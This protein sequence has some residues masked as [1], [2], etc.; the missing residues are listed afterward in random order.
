M[1][2]AGRIVV[3]GAGLAGLRTAEAL[4]RHGWEGT[5]TIIGDEPHLPYTRPPLSKKLLAEGGDHA[6]VELRRREEEHETEWLLGLAVAGVDLERKVVGLDDG[7]ELAYDGLVVATGVRARR[8]PPAVGAGTTVLRSLDDALALEPR[9]VPGARVVVIG[10]GFIG[11]EVA[12]TALGRGCEV[13]VV[14]VDEEPMQVPLGTGVGAE[15]RRRH[16]EAG[17][18]FHL[19]VGVSSIDPAGVDLA[20]GTRL[21]ADVIVEAIGSVPNTEWLAGNGLDLTDGVECDAF[22]RPGGVAGVVAVGDVARFPNAGPGGAGGLDGVPRRIEHWQVA[23]DTA[24]YAARVLL[25]DLAG[26]AWDQPFGTLPTFWSD[27]GALSLRAVG[28]PGLGEETEVLEGDLS[29]EVAV[30]YRRE[31]RLVGVVLLGLPKRMGAYLQLLTAEAAAS[32]EPA[33]ARS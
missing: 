25:A 22:L 23:V 28:Q 26:T 7:S 2:T 31:G 9:L 27:Q 11:C 4:R 30:G 12:A 29:G 24:M 15:L 1:S 3:A 20:D 16:T 6:S 21:E 32:A 13:S 10:A 19:G 14:A 8:L 18:G 5:V 33:G 17:I